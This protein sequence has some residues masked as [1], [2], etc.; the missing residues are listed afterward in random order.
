MRGVDI[1]VVVSD[2]GSTDGTAGF[3]AELAQRDPRVRVLRPDR[4]LGLYANHNFAYSR[5]RGEFVCFFHDDDRYG[6]DI[7]SRYVEFFATNPRVGVVCADYQRIDELGRV[8][9]VR[10]SRV[11]PVTSGI[12]YIDRTLRTGRSS[13]LLSGCLIRRTALP[14]QPFDEM[15]T[16]GFSDIALWFRIAEDWDIGHV[17]EPLWSYRQHAGAASQRASEIA[18]EFA[19]TFETYCDGYLARHPDDR[20]RV[21][22]WREAI[23][24]FRFWAIL[25]DVATRSTTIGPVAIPLGTRARELGELAKGPLEHVAAGVVRGLL[26]VGL[27]RI[28][29][30]LLRYTRVTRALVLTR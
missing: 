20:Q 16:I 17:S 19:M 12:E 6:P 15:G 25:Y 4:P 14:A 11:A 1:E 9:A 8:F 27:G 21:R 23:R 18:G 3:L 5:A 29:G 24:R 2:N 30:V 7:L 10:R 28:L 26:R 22:R 13:L